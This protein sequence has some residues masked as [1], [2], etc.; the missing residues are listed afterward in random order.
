MGCSGL[1]FISFSLYFF[2]VFSCPIAFNTRSEIV[3]IW[4]ELGSV[5]VT[6]Y[7]NNTGV[8]TSVLFVCLFVV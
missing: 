5:K 3:D 8:G 1:Y 4:W 2:S 6:H 7:K